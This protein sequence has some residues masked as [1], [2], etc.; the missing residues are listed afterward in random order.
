MFAS[1]GGLSRLVIYQQLGC[2]AG[3]EQ[4]CLQRRPNGSVTPMLGQDVSR[5]LRSWHVVELDHTC[6][7]GL[8]NKVVSKGMVALLQRRMRNCRTCYHRCVVTKHGRGT[9]HWN[10][11]VAKGNA[12]RHGLLCSCLGGD[13]LGPIRLL[14]RQ[15][16][17][18]CRTTRWV[19][20]WPSVGRQ[21]QL[22]QS[23]SHDTS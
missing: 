14:L 5:V 10:S 19:S 18:S 20:D 2:V 4:D 22:A 8:T 13:K 15:S 17:A 21:S 11:K 6:C 9:C 16:L 3:P 7:N 12:G 1:V 23:P